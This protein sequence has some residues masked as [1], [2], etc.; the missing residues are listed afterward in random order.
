MNRTLTVALIALLLAALACSSLV[1]V[2]LT[3]LQTGPR[4]SFS[5]DEPM[6]DGSPIRDAWLMMAPSSAMLMLAGG[7][8]GLV[9]G[10]IRYNIAEWEPTLN[11]S[12]G[13][14]R[15][16]QDVTGSQIQGIPEETVNEWKLNLGDEVMNVQVDCPAGDFILD[17]ADSLPDGM[18][19]A[20]DM[21]AGKLRL[22]IP[23]GVAATVQVTRGPSAVTT[24]G[25][26]SQNGSSY[27]IDG[28]GPAWTIDVNMG[29]GNLTLANR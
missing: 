20:V 2:P 18:A 14:L 27:R 15:I 8:S 5:I 1:N 24:E 13:T 22:V 6:P 26:W 29:V 12:N 17:F 4:E 11:T 16:V 21:G 25:G 28:P 3:K 7:A 19:I 10:E 9:E 23:E